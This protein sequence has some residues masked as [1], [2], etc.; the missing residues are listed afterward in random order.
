MGAGYA[1]PFLRCSKEANERL[2]R[3]RKGA[4]MTC[5]IFQALKDAEKNKRKDA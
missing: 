4:N 5:E 2:P 3:D 1:N